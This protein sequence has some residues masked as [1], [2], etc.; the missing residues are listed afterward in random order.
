MNFLLHVWIK[1]FSVEYPSEKILT[2]GT[3][4]YDFQADFG[5]RRWQTVLQSGCTQVLKAGPGAEWHGRR[6]SSL[7][8]PQWGVLEAG[9]T[10]EKG[11][12][13][14]KPSPPKSSIPH[15]NAGALPAEQLPSNHKITIPAGKPSLAATDSWWT[16]P[17]FRF[18]NC[19]LSAGNMLHVTMMS[20][21]FSPQRT[22][23]WDGKTS[24]PSLP[25]AMLRSIS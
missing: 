17:R 23:R 20:S 8:N 18:A 2:A 21:C 11:K 12:V 3:L 25:L 16:T 19:Y 6:H 5:S 15:H 24:P 4:W 9:I 14:P 13:L 22:E 7:T 1:C 10:G